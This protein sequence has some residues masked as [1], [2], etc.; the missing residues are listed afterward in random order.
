MSGIRN[1]IREKFAAAAGNGA[2]LIQQFDTE[3]RAWVIRHNPYYGVAIEYNGPDFFESF[4][5]AAL[6]S[7]SISI[8]GENLEVLFLFSSDIEKREAFASICSDFVDPGQNG[9]KRKFVRDHPLDWWISWKELLG[10]AEDELKIYD[11]LGELLAV[12]KL[13]REGEKPKWA[14]IEK[15]SHDIETASCAYEIKST[16]RK[17]VSQIHISS[18]FQLDSKRPLYLIFNRFEPSILGESLDSTM[19]ELKKADPTNVE[20]YEK[21]LAS[22]G[23]AKGNH[24]RRVQFKI[25]ERR[26]YLIDENFPKI[27]EESFKGKKFPKGIAHIEYDVDLDGLQ[28]ENWDA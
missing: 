15:G 27:V 23:F 1:E 16:R 21:Y 22:K 11:V 17:A 10:N 4:A 5:S 18:Q 20:R 8:G 9:I 25:L 12:L 13:I 6:R 24:Y 26:K 28:F 7:Q 3:N 2:Y 14:A 19:E